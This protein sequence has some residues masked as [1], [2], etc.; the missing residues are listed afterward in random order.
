[1][2][3]LEPLLTAIVARRKE[4]PAERALLVGISGIDGSGKGFVAQ[5]V[6]ESLGVVAGGVEPGA[7]ESTLGAT[8]ITDPGYKVAVIGVDGW[9]N[10]P[11]VRFAAE[12]CGEH[13]YRNAFRFDE[14]F[15]RLILPLRDRRSV[16]LEMDFTEETASCHRKHRYHFNQIEVILLEGI[17]LFKPAY[18]HHFD[19][20]CW[21]DCSF[22]TALARA[23]KRGQ[24]GLPPEE[25]VR[26][27]ETIY[28]PAQRMHLQRDN[29]RAT[30]ELILPN[31]TKEAILTQSEQHPT[32]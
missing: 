18:R 22:A 7:G 3:Q 4:I 15:E 32:W 12:D 1:M 6:A 13:F 16:D 31:D 10:L 5:R 24:E 23:V 25:T 2:V 30:A 19:L 29:P 20:T 17:F 26:A 14:M 27:F 9:L 11:H 8:G 28:F 21:I